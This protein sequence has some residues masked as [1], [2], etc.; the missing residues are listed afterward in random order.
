MHLDEIK[1]ILEQLDSSDA[2][3]IVRAQKLAN[4]PS[5]KRDLAFIHANLTF[6]PVS[7][8]QLEAKGLTVVDACQIMEDVKE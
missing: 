6:L 5:V 2:P 3:S 1:E 8:K 7:I 4:M